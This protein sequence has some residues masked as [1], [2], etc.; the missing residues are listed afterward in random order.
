MQEGYALDY[1]YQNDS[2][3]DIPLLYA[4]PVDQVP[5]ASVADIPENTQL[6]DFQRVS[7]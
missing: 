7:G 1:V 6:P 3:A 5:Y 4:R 2:L